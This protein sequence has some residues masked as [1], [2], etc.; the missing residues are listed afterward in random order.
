VIRTLFSF[1]ITSQLQK[2]HL[3]AVFRFHRRTKLTPLQEPSFAAQAQR[4]G[5]ALKRLGGLNRS[6]QLIEAAA[7][8]RRGEN[9]PTNVPWLSHGE[10]R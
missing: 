1:F 8:G 6:L 2:S 4:L 9:V 5:A 3:N 10:K 7:E